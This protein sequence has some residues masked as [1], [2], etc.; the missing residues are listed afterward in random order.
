MRNSFT[1]SF[2]YRSNIGIDLSFHLLNIVLF[3]LSGANRVTIA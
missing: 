2:S 1:K 3:A